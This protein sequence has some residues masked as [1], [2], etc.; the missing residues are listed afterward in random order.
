V[1]F[2]NMA[3]FLMRSAHYGGFARRALVLAHPRPFRQSP[4]ETRI[5][6]DHAWQD[7]ATRASGCSSPA[8]SI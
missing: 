4:D 2:S 7:P 1:G 5:F 3:K 8:S 6:P